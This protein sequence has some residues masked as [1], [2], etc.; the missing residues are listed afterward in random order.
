[1]VAGVTPKIKSIPEWLTTHSLVPYNDATIP[2][3]YK[4]ARLKLEKDI[5]G[6]SAGVKQLDAIVKDL[7]DNTNAL[8]EAADTSGIRINPMELVKEIRTRGIAAAADNPA[9]DVATATQVAY[10]K[11]ADNLLQYLQNMGKKDR[12]IYVFGAAKLP[13]EIL[14]STLIQWRRNLGKDLDQVW[15]QL[16]STGEIGTHAGKRAAVG[17]Y[18][19]YNTHLKGAVEGLDVLDE[20]SSQSRKLR[21]MLQNQSEGRFRGALVP[22]DVAMPALIESTTRGAPGTVTAIAGVRR[23]MSTIEDVIGRYIYNRMQGR[24]HFWKNP[25]ATKMRK[26][27]QPLE[28]AYSEGAFL[29]TL[30]EKEEKKNN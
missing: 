18:G 7:T 4:A 8:I 13:E 23:L 21:T 27:V 11:I 25:T 12:D 9:S 3:F 14:P 22:S 2:E 17:H 20:A 24:P 29:S 28:A 16:H 6:G 1:M 5:A 15:K 30:L 26:A 10:N 19:A